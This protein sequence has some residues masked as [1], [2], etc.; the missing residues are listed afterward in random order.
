MCKSTMISKD[1]ERT[2]K[3]CFIT[4]LEDITKASEGIRNHWA[5][6]NNLHWSLGVIFK[7]DEYRVL[8]K[9]ASENLA[10]ISYN[11]ANNTQ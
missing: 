5:I 7:D 9:N 3:C 6:E 2:D 10:T 11:E 4:S 8:D 1:K